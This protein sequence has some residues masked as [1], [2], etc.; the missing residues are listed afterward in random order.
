MRML[1]LTS[2]YSTSGLLMATI[3]T[4]LA[5]GFS[6]APEAARQELR[7]QTQ[8]RVTTIEVSPPVTVTHSDNRRTPPL[9]PACSDQPDFQ[10]RK[11]CADK[12]MLEYIY[13]HI[14]YP[15]E[16]RDAGAEGMVVVR[17]TVDARGQTGIPV[18]IKSPHPALGTV[19]LKVIQRMLR[20]TAV[21]EPARENDTPVA[22]EFNLPIQFKLN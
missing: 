21:W 11:A 7:S 4:L 16:A 1:G 8:L 20:R 3:M 22:T 12:A 2:R 14:R 13:E 15:K 18:V 19:S 9:Y 6:S 17:F 5:W 10:Q